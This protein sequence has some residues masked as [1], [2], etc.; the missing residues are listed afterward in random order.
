MYEMKEQSP[1][2]KALNHDGHL[3]LTFSPGRIQTVLTDCYQVPPLKASRALYLN[4]VD[5]AE[6][7]LY[8]M[9]SS[10]GLVEGDSNNYKIKVEDGAKVCLIPQSATLVYPSYHDGWGS[11][12]NSIRLKGNATLKWQPESIIPFAN[13]QFK[14]T[15]EVKMDREATLLWGEI[16]SPGRYK[17]N[18][19]FEYCRFQTKFHVWM[20]DQCLI[21]DNLDFSPTA[22]EL[23]QL[24]LLEGYL[25]IGSI[26]LVSA[27]AKDLDLQDL[28]NE[29]KKL[30]DIKV[31]T[32]LLDSKVLSIRFLSS[33]MVY[34]KKG[35]DKIWTY[36]NTKI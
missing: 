12:H 4:P 18:E 23:N 3:V 17:R 32:S 8:L 35:M 34:L 14:G 25:H 5:P 10:G 24:G 16:I 29:F 2:K 20:E 7:S 6:A 13:S 31:G 26:W 33:E 11:Q 21:Y 36:L 22:M 28:R 19:I 1:Y 27:T 30:I 15:T 9:Q